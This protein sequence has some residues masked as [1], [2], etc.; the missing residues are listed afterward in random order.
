MQFGSP[1]DYV[2]L[3]TPQTTTTSTMK[4]GAECLSETL[5]LAYGQIR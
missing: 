1:P 2:V 4:M 5:V 3:I